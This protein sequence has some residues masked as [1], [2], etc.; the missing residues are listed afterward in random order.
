[1][2]KKNFMTVVTLAAVLV[3]AF[4]AMTSGA[5]FTDQASIENTTISMGTLEIE[6]TG[7]AVNVTEA[8]PGHTFPAAY[9]IKNAGTLP[10]KYSVQAPIAATISRDMQA[11]YAFL[12][13]EIYDAGGIKKGEGW[14]RDLNVTLNPELA[15][16]ESEGYKF[17]FTISQN[18]GNELK[19]AKT[20]FNLVFNAVQVQQ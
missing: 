14:L 10:L 17:V 13:V 2:I 1:M 5:W 4:G 18:V 19:G 11:L 15:P 16:G 12:Y 9:I 6:A 8:F 7:V 20:Q 3:M